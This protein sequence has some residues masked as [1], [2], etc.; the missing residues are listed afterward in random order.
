MGNDPRP[1][2]PRNG[3]YSGY[4]STGSGAERVPN[5]RFSASQG[6][7][8]RR[9]GV[10]LTP[11]TGGDAPDRLWTRAEI[12]AIRRGGAVLAGR[13][14]SAGPCASSGRRSVR[15][16]RGPRDTYG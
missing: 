12:A 16:G 3:S 1:S 9:A 14:P 15:D 13:A 5:G 6:I 10:A 11:H 8:H 4:P 2:L 7:E